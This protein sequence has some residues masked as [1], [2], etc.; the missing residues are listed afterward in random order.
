MRP[1]KARGA[2]SSLPEAGALLESAATVSASRRNRVRQ[3]I[4]WAGLV[5]G[6]FDAIFAVV[7]YKQPATAIFHSVA[8]GLIGKAA[9]DGGIATA[10]LGAFLH[11]LIA[12]SWGAAYI[13]ASSRLRVLAR[14]WVPCGIAYGVLV[15]FAMN[16][17]VLPLSRVSFA[18]SFQMAFFQNKI[19]LA[20]LIGHMVLIGLPIAFF[21]R[22]AHSR[23]A[24]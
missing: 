23:A 19:W 6:T 9:Y 14:Q 20:G 4:L 13:V 22:R 24:R 18:R 8:S 1:P 11:Y 21:A 17:V 5:V 3:S 7:L 12:T 2:P 10:I 15:Y 16:Y